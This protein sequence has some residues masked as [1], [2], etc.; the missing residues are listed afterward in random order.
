MHPPLPSS[1]KT[2]LSSKSHTHGSIYF[3]SSLPSLGP[4]SSFCMNSWICHI[5]RIIQ[6]VTFC[7]W[8]FKIYCVVHSVHPFSL[9]A[10]TAST[11]GNS[12]LYSISLIN[13]SLFSLLFSHSLLSHTLEIFIAQL[14]DLQD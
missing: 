9:E 6:Y 5:N 4:Q 7:V 2:F 1:S 10:H 14:L 3:P 12:F 13:S 8:A 11:L